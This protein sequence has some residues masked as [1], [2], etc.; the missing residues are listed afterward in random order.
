MPAST[1]KVSRAPRR[2]IGRQHD[3]QTVLT[4]VTGAGDEPV[5]V[6]LTFERFELL[7]QRSAG[8]GHQFGNLVPGVRA[9]N[10]QHRQLG[11]LVELH[12][13]VA[14]MSLHPGQVLIAGGGVDHQPISVI[15]AI[16]DHVIDDTAVLVEHGAVQGTAGAVQALDV[17]GQ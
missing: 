6:G 11:T 12:I 5:T 17:V 2:L 1:R 15:E 16:D 14:E 7:D 13:E 8:L 3:F 4:G 9:L 10:G